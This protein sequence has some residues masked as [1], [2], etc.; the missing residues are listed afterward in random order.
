M[1]QSG[2]VGFGT[3]NLYGGGQRAQSVALVRA[4]IDAGISWIDT[5]PLYGHGAAEAIVGE[6]IHGRRDNLVLVSKAG[7]L[8]TAITLRHR[9]HGK[10]AAIAGKLPG[11]TRLVA[12]P[13]PLRPR[14]GAFAPT[15]VIASVERSLIA[16]GTDR[17]DYLLLHEVAP[18]T[19]ADPALLDALDGLVRDGKV[20]AYG[21]ATQLESTRAIAA[22][23]HA[24][25][26]ALLQIAG[27]ATDRDSL[28]GKPVVLHSILGEALRSALALLKTD[29]ALRDAARALDIDPDQPDLAR[30][31]MAAAL[32]REG[33]VA[34]LFSTSNPDRLRRM[35]DLTGVS[36][37]AA[38]AGMKLMALAAQS[39]P[40]PHP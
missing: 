13:A 25:R 37:A 20:L 3:G 29:A 39:Q 21:T 7:I 30:R 12:P 24:D 5:A 4:A 17:L 35:A 26:F 34:A 2:R 32:R 14:F 6:A 1:G 18:A 11:G 27:T 23:P 9:L 40:R 22:A 10:A 36:Q 8:P 38:E 15:D 16:L 31:L 19:A 28:Q 33:V